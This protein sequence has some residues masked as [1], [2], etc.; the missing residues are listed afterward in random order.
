M[1]HASH[2]LAWMKY[3]RSMREE[4]FEWVVFA[5]LAPARPG[6]ACSTWKPRWLQTRISGRFPP[7][8]QQVTGRGR[9]E[10]RKPN[11]VAIRARIRDGSRL[12]FCERQLRD[13]S[14]ELPVNSLSLSEI[15]RVW[16]E[17]KIQLEFANIPVYFRALWCAPWTSPWD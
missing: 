5:C 11:H 13:K 17:F 9:R 3:S 7:A 14:T 4:S 2:G 12:I 15:C 10:P 8:T 1:R 6:N 16:A